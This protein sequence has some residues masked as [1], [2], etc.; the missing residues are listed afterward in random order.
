[1]TKTIN[2]LNNQQV[3]LGGDTVFYLFHMKEKGHEQVRYY[4]FERSDQV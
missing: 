3:R 2:L 4:R 1:M